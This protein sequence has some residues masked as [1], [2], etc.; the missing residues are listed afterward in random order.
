MMAALYEKHLPIR[1]ERWQDGLPWDIFED[2]LMGFRETI[3]KT[4]RSMPEPMRFD[5]T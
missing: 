2:D 4:S 5:M 1:F 3:S